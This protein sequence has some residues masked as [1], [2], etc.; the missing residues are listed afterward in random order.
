MAARSVPP[1]SVAAGVL[2]ELSEELSSSP[3]A[4][5]KSRAEARK[6]V[7]TRIRET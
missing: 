6:I 2:S 4:A 3:Q 1:A 7:K 5:R